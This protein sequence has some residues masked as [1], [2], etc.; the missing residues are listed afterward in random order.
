MAWHGIAA[1]GVQRIASR[2]RAFVHPSTP[3]GTHRFLTRLC[4]ST[5]P[6]KHV[7]IY[8]NWTPATARPVLSG[9]DTAANHCHRIAVWCNPRLSLLSART[10]TTEKT[11]SQTRRHGKTRLLPTARRP[12]V[13]QSPILLA[14]TCARR[15]D[16]FL[17]GPARENLSHTTHHTP[18]PSPPCV[19]LPPSPADAVFPFPRVHP[20][21]PAASLRA[22]SACHSPRLTPL[23]S[24]PPGSPLPCLHPTTVSSTPSR[25]PLQPEDRAVKACRK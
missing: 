5:A 8:S 12:P 16:R 23:P 24:L 20:V 15:E 17:V 10:T 13:Q 7:T 19:R 21:S 6:T 9:A 14:A 11:C 3:P 1:H 2:H 4:R 22:L 18:H 25:P